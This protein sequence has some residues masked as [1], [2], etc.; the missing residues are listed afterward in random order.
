MKKIFGLLLLSGFLLA[1]CSATKVTGVWQDENFQGKPF[2]NILV[3]S[4]FLDGEVGRMSEFQLARLL[5]K[6]GVSASA[7]HVVLPTGSRSSVEKITEVIGKHSFDG[8]LISRIVDR[9]EETRTIAQ[10][11]CKSRWDSDYRQTQRYSLSP[12]QPG[13][14]TRTTAVYGLETK[15]YSAKDKALVMSLASA[16]SADRP[17]D[18]LIKGFVKTVVDHL[19][20]AGL[21]AKP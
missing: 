21:L 16:T 12:C 7:G 18:T 6:K 3:V 17:T 2:E 8:I 1:A 19:S 15:L 4:F 14:M 5:R 9:V 11:A 13:S 20:R 10:G